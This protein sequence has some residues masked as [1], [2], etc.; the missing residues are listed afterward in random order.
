MRPVYAEAKGFNQAEWGLDHGDSVVTLIVP[1]RESH[2]AIHT[3][4]ARQ[5]VS[6]DLYTCGDPAKGRQAIESL[7]QR[8]AGEGTIKTVWRGEDL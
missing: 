8:L 5:L 1:L 6:L 2:L 4:P 7:Q 3:W